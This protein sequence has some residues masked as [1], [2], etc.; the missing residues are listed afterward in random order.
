MRVQLCWK[1]KGE[2]I[3][4]CLLSMPV[5]DAR[6][7]FAKIDNDEIVLA[8]LRRWEGYGYICHKVLK[9]NEREK[10]KENLITKG[11]I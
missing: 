10:S 4:H 7:A 8:Y 3:L 1:K 6:K 11:N 2:S 9:D 5:K